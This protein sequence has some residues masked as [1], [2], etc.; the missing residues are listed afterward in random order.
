MFH[1]QIKQDIPVTENTVNSYMFSKLLPFRNYS[2]YVSMLNA[3]GEGPAAETT[4]STPN[5]PAVKDNEPEPTLILGSEYSILSQGAD[6]LSE[7]QKVFYRSEH[8]IVGVAIHVAKQL[9]FV[10]E[11]NG[12]VFR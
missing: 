10:A 9:V 4:L 11:E 8:R 7:P 1:L 3:E 6:I 12:Y 5:E 2:I